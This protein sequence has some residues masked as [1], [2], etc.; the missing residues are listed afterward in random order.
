LRLLPQGDLLVAMNALQRFGLCLRLLTL[1]AAIAGMA[2]AQAQGGY[3]GKPYQ[4]RRQVIPGRIEMEFYD[5]GGQGVAYN[6]TDAVNNGSGTL[7]KGDTYLDRFRQD[8]GVDIS[9]TKNNID[10]TV[11]GVQEKVGELYLGWTAP[12]EWVNYSVDVKASGTYI[13]KAH[14]SSRTDAAQVSIAIDGVDKTGPILLP[15]TTHWHIWRIAS[16]L[17]QVKLDQGPHVMKLS[18]LKEGNFN[19]DYLEFVPLDSVAASAGF[20]P[21]DAFDQVKQMGRGLNI[22]GYDPLWQ[23][24]SKARFQDRHFRRISE[25]GFQ[26]VRINL[27]AFAHMD[28]SNQLS[29]SWF[30]TLDWAVNTALTNNLTVILD[31]HN[32]NA[33]G[34][35]AVSCEPKLMAFWSQVS[36]HYKDAPVKVVF[37]ILNEPNSKLTPELWN[38]YAREALAIIRKTN[39]ARNVIIG[40]ANWNSIHALDKLD[41]PENDRHIIVTVHYYLPMS[42]THQ[43]AS[44]AK[45]YTKLSG[46]TW[47]TE[48]DKRRVDADFAGV[49]KWAVAANRPILL[50]EFGAYDKGDMDSRVR[51]TSYVAR[52]A[53]S[54]GWTWTYWQFDADFIAYNMAND[55]WVGPIHSALVP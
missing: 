10:K 40:P 9:Y 13:I 18:V 2:E 39:P 51:Y 41:L 3:Q 34:E 33:C 54:L 7:N 12:G 5:T 38:S 31:E 25:G 44:W 28:A 14:M 27:H 43:G 46:V 24:F 47:G 21:V 4:G 30:K 35:D 23:D 45:E 26:T 1:A 6:D 36:D 16:N 53:E 52:T 11:D 49:Q 48:E 17:A 20:E 22:I 32:Y 50:G 42:F 19:L 8:E 15:T 29:A 37:E 55:D